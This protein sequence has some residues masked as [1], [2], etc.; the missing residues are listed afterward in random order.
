MRETLTNGLEYFQQL[1]GQKADKHT[2]K[3]VPD[4]ETTKA[5]LQVEAN[6]TW[7]LGE[8]ERA[9]YMGRIATGAKGSSAIKGEKSTRKSKEGRGN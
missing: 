3:R 6:P 2:P 5:T 9:R 1:Y 8:V 4:C 7:L